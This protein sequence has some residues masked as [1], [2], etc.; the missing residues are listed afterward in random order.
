[1]P[2]PRLLYASL[3]LAVTLS[4]AACSERG[5]GELVIQPVTAEELIDEIRDADADLVVVNFWA[6]WC[7]PCREEFPE[8]VRFS[9]ETDPDDV[10]VRFVTVDFE[11]DLPF[12]AQFLRENG[13]GGTTFVKNGKE[14]PFINVIN[15]GWSGAIPATAIYDRDGNRLAFWE[16]KVTYDQLLRRVSEARQAS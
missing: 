8:F 7:M 12:A 9:R 2:E 13:V 11:E 1:M 16:G 6:S 15:P 14:G 10:Q 4:L 3:I 5:P